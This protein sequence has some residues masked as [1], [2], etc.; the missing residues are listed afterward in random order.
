M[1]TVLVDELLVS[2]F[3]FMF[4]GMTFDSKKVHSDVVF[5]LGVVK[6]IRLWGK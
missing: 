2:I 5:L 1:P 6:A 3:Q 4:A